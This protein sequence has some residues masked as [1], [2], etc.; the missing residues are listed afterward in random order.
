VAKR[1]VMLHTFLSLPTYGGERLAS[2]TGHFYPR[3]KYFKDSSLLGFDNMSLM[4][5]YWH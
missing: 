4:S 3:K 5:H 2:Q 1:S